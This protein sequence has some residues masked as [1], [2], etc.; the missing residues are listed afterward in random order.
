MSLAEFISHRE[1]FFH[2][3]ERE[4]QTCSSILSVALWSM[5]PLDGI[6]FCLR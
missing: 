2:A 3:S 1:R 5:N 6:G 4:R